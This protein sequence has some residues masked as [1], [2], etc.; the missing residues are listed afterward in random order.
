MHEVCV[1]DI[2]MKLGTSI[3]TVTESSEIAYIA[4]PTPTS[5]TTGKCDTAL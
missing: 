2:S 5:E 3:S 1:H 4:V